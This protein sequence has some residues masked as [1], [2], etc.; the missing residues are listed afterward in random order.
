M[1]AVELFAKA[2]V[3]RADVGRELGVSH[4]TVLDWHAVWNQGGTEALRCA[5]RAGQRGDRR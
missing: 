2:D 5:G 1:R 4:Q 3:R